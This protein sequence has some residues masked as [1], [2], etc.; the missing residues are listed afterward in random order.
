[1]FAEANY[2]FAGGQTVAQVSHGDDK[3]LYV[4]FYSEPIL[5]TFKSQQEN[6]PIHEERDFIT[7]FFPGDKTKKV[8]REVKLQDDADGP[9]DLRRF[10]MQWNAYK[11][12]R[13]SAH[14]G[15]PLSE[16]T[17]LSKSE[18]ADLKALKIFTI[19]QLAG[20]SDSN[21]SWLGARQLRDRAKLWM[22]QAQGGAPL[23]RLQSELEHRDNIIEQ[24]SSKLQ[25]LTDLVDQQQRQLES[26][27][28]V[29]TK[30]KAK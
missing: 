17:Q 18:V 21:L 12:Q 26:Q 19:E 11:E 28:E 6:R 16:W 7:I 24:M 10:P 9:S 23:A 2:N 25:A 15:T 3:G 29:A 30:S 4:E 14:D 27:G 8:V 13:E 20:M 22:E 5:N 1:M